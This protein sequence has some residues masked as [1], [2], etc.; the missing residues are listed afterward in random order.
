MPTQ[1]PVP[2][3]PKGSRNNTRNSKRTTTPYTQKPTLLATPPSSPP[4]HMSPGGTATDTSN[5]A[6][7]SKKKNVRSGK[8][9]RDANNT[10]HRHTSSQP[11]NITTPQLK[12]SS[13]YAGPT[14][15]ASPAPSAL[16]IP[17]F[18]SKSVPDSDLEP[19]LELES[20]QIET[21]PELDTTPSK[22]KFR[23]DTGDQPQSTPLDFLFKAAAEARNTNAQRSPEANTKIRSPQTDSKA[24]SQNS[25]NGMNNGYFPFE[26]D[27]NE[28]HNLRI[29]PSF[30]PSYKDRMD[31]LR[32]SSSPSR[33]STSPG[34]DERRAKTEELKNL[35]LN[36]KPQRPPSSTHLAHG[37]AS[38]VKV[39]PSASPTVPHFATPLRTSSGPPATMSYGLTQEQRKPAAEFN[40]YSPSSV[41]QYQTQQSA[42]RHQVSS[43]GPGDMGGAPERFPS[44]STA[45]IHSGFT[46]PHVRQPRYGTPTYPQPVTARAMPASQSPQPVDTKKMEDDLRRILKLDSMPSSGVQSSY[47]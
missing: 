19:A 10:G 27:G 4:K 44:P 35:L 46:N 14:F 37:Q 11:N 21:E 15:H 41:K 8:K 18:I 13:H 45:Q 34:E 9:P 31:A 47:A 22:P 32:S 39:R 24:T 28:S 17:S 38:N 5:T 36:P 1:S 16:P 20:D 6:K 40:P 29:G 42:L 12:D 26:M 25:Y 43:P 3:T 7:S 33:P 30:A 2:P 23:P